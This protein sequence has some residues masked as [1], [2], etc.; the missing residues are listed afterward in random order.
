M[1]P[2]NPDYIMLWVA[3]TTCFF[4]F[5]RSGEVTSPKHQFDEGAHLAF[6]D[7]ILD[8]RSSPKLVQVKIKASKADPSRH[9]ISIFLGT[10]N[11]E[12]C[13]VAAMAANRSKQILISNRTGIL[14]TSNTS[15][16]W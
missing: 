2:K 15:Q 16:G 10:T 1:Q 8:L 5:L 14:G 6:G 7:V 13:T 12:L 4:V 3:C 9:G 11:N